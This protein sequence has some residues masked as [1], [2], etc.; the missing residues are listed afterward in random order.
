LPDDGS[1]HACEQQL[2]LLLADGSNRRATAG[3]GNATV[4]GRTITWTSSATGVAT[5]DASGKVTAH[6]VGTATI[7]ARD[8]YDN[9]IGT[10]T[11]NVGL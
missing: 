7:T 10:A 6:A 3:R 5:V 11:I 8:V 2:S 4:T 9:V 1:G